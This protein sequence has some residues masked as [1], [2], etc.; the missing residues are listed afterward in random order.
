MLQNIRQIALL[1]KVFDVRGN[2]WSRISIAWAIRFLYRSGFVV[3]WTVI[4]A[5]FVSK[6]GIFSLPYLFVMKAVFTV[7]GSVFYSVFV[8]KFS[9]Q[10]LM[11]TSIVVACFTLFVAYA[12][13]S[14]SEILYFTLLVVVISVFLNQFRILFDGNVEEMF[15]PLESERVFPIIEAAYTLGGGVAGLLVTFL[16]GVINVFSFVFLWIGLLLLII[17]FLLLYKVVNRRVALVCVEKPKRRNNKNVFSRLRTV[18]SGKEDRG[19]VRGLVVVVLLQWIIFNLL[20]FQY[21]KAV[22]QN[23]SNVVIDAGSGFEHAF[24]H[25][26]GILF[27][28]FSF[29]ALLFQIFIA[30]RLLK[31]LGI[32]GGMV[33]H[34]VVTLLSFLG[35]ISSFSFSTAVLGKNNFTITS[36]IFTNA[37]HSSYYGVDDEARSHVREFLEGVVVPVGA[38]VGT[39]LLLLI[40]KLFE[41]N[42]LIFYVNLLMVGFSLLFFYFTYRQQ[43]RYTGV[44]LSDLIYSKDKNV[45]LNAVEILSQRGH[46]DA[47]GA[48]EKVLINKNEPISL[49]VRI[50][51]G[52][53]ELNHPRAIPLIIDCLKSGNAVIREAAVDALLEYKT[54]GRKVRNNLVA[55]YK[56]LDSLRLLFKTEKHERIRSKIIKLISNISSVATIDFLL[57]VLKKSKGALKANAIYA[58]GSYNDVSMAEYIKPYLSAKDLDQRVSAMVALSKFPGYEHLLLHNLDLLLASKKQDEVASGLYLIGELRL[59]RKRAICF[60]LVDSTNIDLKIQAAIALAKL[61]YHEV[62][63]LIVKL[64]LSEDLDVAA[65]VKNLLSNVDVR[66]SKNIDKIVRHMVAE[67]VSELII[68]NERKPLREYNVDVLKSLCWMYRLVEEYDEVDSINKILNNN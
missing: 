7:L 59:K 66:I 25:D 13:S 54:V 41:G 21:T 4:V 60:E 23:V 45:R 39:L 20:E 57:S 48:L 68:A 55:N 19:F 15:S 9:R 1:N 51:R 16:S 53:A 2:E 27:M 18:I 58:L 40:Q 6:Y 26:L 34:A 47:F 10:F 22:Y 37:Y 36:V 42:S 5:M 63:P 12:F 14:Y 52:F 38:V 17:P 49:R 28:L 32:I 29:S 3:G 33:L 30:G 46:R 65:R 35:M 24:I 56:L 67:Q 31:S 62:E 61:G 8:D 64:L 50:L 44:A 11:I 43:S